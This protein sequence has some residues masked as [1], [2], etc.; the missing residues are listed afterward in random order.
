MPVHTEFPC[1]CV[2]TTYRSQVVPRDEFYLVP[3]EVHKQDPH[4]FTKLWENSRNGLTGSRPL[5]TLPPY[6]EGPTRCERES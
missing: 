2:S 4:W 3:C 1:G 5:D 6:D